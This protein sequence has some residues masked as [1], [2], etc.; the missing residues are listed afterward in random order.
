MFQN[1]IEQ[2]AVE[3]NQLIMLKKLIMDQIDDQEFDLLNIQ[4]EIP[5]DHYY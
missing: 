5:F 2:C 1:H 4:V 3:R